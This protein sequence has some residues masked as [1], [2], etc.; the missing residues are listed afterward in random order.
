MISDR[1]MNH[2]INHVQERALRIAYKDYRNDFG[3]LLEQSASV[4][5]HLQNLHLLKADFYKTKFHLNPT[6]MKDIFQ[7]QNMNHNLRLGNDAM[8]NSQRCEPSPLE[9]RP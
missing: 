9:L 7:E 6:F 3:Y 1:T 8:L 2:R 5:I 4:P